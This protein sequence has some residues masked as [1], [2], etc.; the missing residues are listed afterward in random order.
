MKT[1]KK[2]LQ[3]RPHPTTEDLIRALPQTAVGVDVSLG[4]WVWYDGSLDGFRGPNEVMIRG[5]SIQYCNFLDGERDYTT[6]W[7]NIYWRKENAI[8]AKEKWIRENNPWL[9]SKDQK[10]KK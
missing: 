5:I 2:K 4:V 1:L 10:N 9:K 3:P 7:D 6:F 8:L